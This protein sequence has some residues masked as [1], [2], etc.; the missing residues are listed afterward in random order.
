MSVSRPAIVCRMCPGRKTEV[1]A[2][3][4]RQVLRC[5]TCRRTWRPYDTYPSPAPDYRTAYSTAPPERE[6]GDALAALEAGLDAA[7]TVAKAAGKRRPDPMAGRLLLL[8]RA[9][10]ADR[11]AYVT[12]LEHLR[13][14]T[15]VT[16]VELALD[17][18]EVAAA[19]LRVF[20]VDTD[21]VYVSGAIRAEHSVWDD[22]PDLGRAYVRQ[23]YTEWTRAERAVF[24]R[25]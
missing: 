13:G 12:E 10:L 11:R 5:R 23:E 16:Q 7:T 2:A 4:G 18:A 9:M 25:T 15:T 17:K 22:E 24:S 1:V 19:A 21:G 8:R 20:D 6:E 14:G 3:E